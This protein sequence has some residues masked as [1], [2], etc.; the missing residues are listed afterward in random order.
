MKFW[1]KDSFNV[2]KIKTKLEE[3]YKI[4]S[5]DNRCIYIFIFNLWEIIAS[6]IRNEYVLDSLANN[7][8]NQII[9]VEVSLFIH[10]EWNQTWVIGLLSTEANG[11]RLEVVPIRNEATLKTIIENHVGLGNTI[12]SDS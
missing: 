9:C 10:N 2:Q 3:L 4:N 7:N 8:A 1:I 5:C 12:Y 6:H 11:I